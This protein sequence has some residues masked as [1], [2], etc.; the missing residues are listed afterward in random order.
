[1]E[2]SEHKPVPALAGYVECFWFARNDARPATTPD[3]VLPDGCIEWI[4]HLD[5]SF[6]VLTPT[7]QWEVQPG[8]FVVGEMTRFILLQPIGRVLTMGVRFRPGGA[9]RFLPFPVDLLTDTFV[10][11]GDIWGREGELLEEAILS[12][13]S[14]RERTLTVETFLIRRLIE[15]APRRRFDAAIGQVL[16]TRG[17]IRVREIAASIGC[18]PRQLEREFRSSAGLSPKSLARVIRFQNLLQ[19]IGE[20]ALLQWANAALDSGYADQPHMVRD[21]REISG[22]SPTEHQAS[23]SGELSRFFVSPQRIKD[24]LGSA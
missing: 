5:D 2:Y 3:R 4:F 23:P 14:D 6:R 16:Q 22:Q 20:G 1:M 10:R 7:K 9:Y 8:S 12:A 19:Q 15:S 17:R 21:F 18:S 13:R 24:L 11:T